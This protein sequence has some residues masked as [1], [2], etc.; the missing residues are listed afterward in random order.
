[1]S[2]T[3][4]A[5]P[6][7]EVSGIRKSYGSVTALH[8]VSLQIRPGEV[9][10]LV[11]DNGAGKSTLVKILSGVTMPSAGT[12]SVAGRPTTFRSPQAA[13]E[14]G[15]ETVYQDLALAPNLTISAN[16][17]LGRERRRR[18]PLGLL[19]VLDRREMD[20]VA[21]AELARLNITVR[22]VQA[23]CDALSG[24]QRQA[25]A[26]ARAVAWGSQVVIMDEPTA[27]LGVEEQ[28]QVAELVTEVRNQGLG[29]LLISHN[30]PQVHERCDRIAVLHQGRLI[31]MLTTSEVSIEDIVMWITGAQ[32]KHD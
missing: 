29:V 24:G 22:S 20:R 25:V 23:K 21:E 26:V 2:T 1:M 7:L 17:Y 15:I 28:Q 27:A 10:G 31:A 9:V 14:A 4:V 30:I 5:E 8:D 11:G 13:R 18:G 16:M 32:L 19:G 12:I 3:T 6:I